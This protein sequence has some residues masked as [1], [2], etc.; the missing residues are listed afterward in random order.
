[1]CR[2]AAFHDGIFMLE[3]ISDWFNLFFP[4]LLGFLLCIS[5][6]YVWVFA[7]KWTLQR[8]LE[9]IKA[10]LY[11]GEARLALNLQDSYRIVAEGRR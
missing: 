8:T 3:S 11:A 6:M 2:V 1:M 9:K 10:Q 4:P 7:K 5:G